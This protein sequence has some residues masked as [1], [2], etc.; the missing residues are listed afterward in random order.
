MK[1]ALII[2]YSFP[3]SNV[4]AA[5]RPFYLAKY[6]NENNWNAE[7]LTHGNTNSSL[8]NSDWVD[9]TKIKIHFTNFK[10]CTNS[11]SFNTI[12]KKNNFEWRKNK[13]LVYLIQFISNWIMIPDKAIFWTRTA[14]KKGVKLHHEKHFDIIISTAPLYTNH[15]VAIGLLRKLN[16]KNKT[17]WVADIRDFF[18]TLGLE[19]TNF[20]L[21]KIFAKYM[22]KKIVMQADLLTFVSQSMQNA[23]AKKY[24]QQANKMKV[25]FNG[26]ESIELDKLNSIEKNKSD[27]I[28]FFYAGSFYNGIRNPE[29]L[30]SSLDILFQKGLI[31]QNQIQ[32]KIAGTIP[33]ELKKKL[34]KYVSFKYALE[35]GLITK[36]QVICESFESDV[37]INIIGDI[38]SHKY[39]LPLKIFEYISFKKPILTIGPTNSE[40][41]NVLKS[42]GTSWSLKSEFINTDDNVKNLSHLIEFI[43]NRKGEYIEFDDKRLQFFNV[44]A[45]LK[46]FY[47]Q[48]NNLL[49]INNA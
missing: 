33:N 29:S 2:S 35:L 3:P 40:S 27:S 18:Y 8:G 7:V 41:E 25:V 20:S 22:E 6:A 32:I 34:M 15:L 13:V 16:K 37:L 30:F 24:P 36:H 26:Y 19:N 31:P 28:T 42:L 48:L 47:E 49:Q 5:H 12:K 44:K 43:R 21:K 10:P 46:Y 1:K 9:L 23:Y 38:P 45:Q 11:I 17:L 4:P 39:T 14:V